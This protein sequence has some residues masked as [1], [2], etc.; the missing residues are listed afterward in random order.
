M[1]Y[2]SADK[3][4]EDIVPTFA[5]E[6]FMKAIDVIEPIQRN[7]FYKILGELLY[8]EN[9]DVIAKEKEKLQQQDKYL[10]ELTSFSW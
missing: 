6:V 7:R 10:A 5:N 3:V 8:K 4:K 1:N 2:P 9:Q